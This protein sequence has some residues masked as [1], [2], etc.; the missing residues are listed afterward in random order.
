MPG[1]R[2]AGERA[3]LVG[4]AAGLIDPVSGDGMYECFVSSR[5]ATDAILDLLAGRARRSRR[6]R[7]PWTRA[8]G[9]LH[10]ASWKLKKALDR[11][12]R[13]SWQIARSR[14]LWIS[15]EGC[16]T[17]SFAIPASSEAWH[18]CRCARSRSSAA[19][20][21]DRALVGTSARTRGHDLRSTELVRRGV[22]AELDGIEQLKQWGPTAIGEAPAEA[23]VSV[24]AGR[25]LQLCS[26]TRVGVIRALMR[27]GVTCL[28]LTAAAAQA[29][30]ERYQTHLPSFR[31]C[32]IC[33]TTLL[34][35]PFSCKTREDGM[36]AKSTSQVREYRYSCQRKNPCV[37]HC[38]LVQRALTRL[39]VLRTPDDC[40]S[41]GRSG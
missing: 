14:L 24:S 29:D 7:R 17:A 32:P 28:R 37:S 19:S 21:R 31:H 16:S 13:A 18:A 38:S 25:Q 15:I 5:L 4:D 9:G 26:V 23:P 22:G 40:D 12:P 8:L 34:P 36:S 39:R 11:W 6:T 30:V 3:L 1:T 41:G 27:A 10:R 33:L 20:S 35:E 2:I